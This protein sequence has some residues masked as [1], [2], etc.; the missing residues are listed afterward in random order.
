MCSPEVTSDALPCSMMRSLPNSMPPCCHSWPDKHAA[1]TGISRMEYLGGR[2]LPQMWICS[3]CQRDRR[4]QSPCLTVHAQ[5]Q[6]AWSQKCMYAKDVVGHWQGPIPLWATLINV[7]A[8][9]YG[10]DANMISYWWV[11]FKRWMSRGLL[12]NS[13]AAKDECL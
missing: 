11:D 5:S 13:Q 2:L 3:Q 4:R 6:C 10:V 12:Y 7:D 1:H 8:R 9:L